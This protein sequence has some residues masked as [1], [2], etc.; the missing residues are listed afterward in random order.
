[1][2]RQLCREMILAC[3][4]RPCRAQASWSLLVTGKSVKAQSCRATMH[5]FV[6]PLSRLLELWS[7]VFQEARPRAAQCRVMIRVLQTREDPCRM[8]MI[9][10]RAN[11]NLPRVRN[12]C[13]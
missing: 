12:H 2:T 4:M 8:N 10:R 3:V 11:T 1:M 7:S 9:T 5:A 6:P 13:S